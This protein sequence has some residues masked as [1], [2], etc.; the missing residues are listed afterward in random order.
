MNIAQYLQNQKEIESLQKQNKAFLKSV[1]KEA[2]DSCPFK[3]GDT[4]KGEEL[5][6]GKIRA[7]RVERLKVL[8]IK[9]DGAFQIVAQGYP[10]KLNGSHNGRDKWTTRNICI[11][12]KTKKL[13]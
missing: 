6:S 5:G 9:D 13:N 12:E 7:V 3:I 10:M 11:N 4:I 2:I 1:Q 8:S